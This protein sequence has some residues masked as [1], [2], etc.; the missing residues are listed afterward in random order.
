MPNH[1][2]NELIFRSVDT[3][4]QDRILAAACNADGKVDF[5][6]LVPPP[7]NLWMGSVGSEHERAFG[8]TGLA[9]NRENWG[10]KWNAYSHKAIE[11]TPDCLILRFETA[12]SP[13]YPW[14]AAIFNDLNLSFDHNWLDEGAERGVSGT[15]LADDGT[16]SSW[17][18]EWKESPASEDIHRHLHKLHWGVE[19]F[20]PEDDA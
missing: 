6:V 9:W 16:T 5:A 2:I 19:E 12:W 1:V 15:F 20:E 7:L 18:P 4:A 3:A 8:R 10:T 17:G 13:P 11:R 14:L